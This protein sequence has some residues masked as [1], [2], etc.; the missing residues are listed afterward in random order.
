M[1]K[2]LTLLMVFVSAAISL[3]FGYKAVT[4]NRDFLGVKTGYDNVFEL[5]FDRSGAVYPEPQGE[6]LVIPRHQRMFDDFY[7]GRV[8]DYF[9]KGRISKN[10]ADIEPETLKSYTETIRSALS[11]PDHTRLILLIHGFNVPYAEARKNYEDCQR[12]I[13]GAGGDKKNVYVRLYWDG[14]CSTLFGGESGL[15]DQWLNVC[16][17]SVAVGAYGVRRFLNYLYNDTLADLPVVI[18]SH[19]RGGAVIASA[20]WDYSSARNQ[21]AQQP[22]TFQ[23]NR[24]VIG[25]LAPAMV[26]QAIKPDACK[27]TWSVIIGFNPEDEFNRKFMNPPPGFFGSTQLGCVLSECRELEKMMKGKLSRI[28]FSGEDHG[29]DHYLHNKGKIFVNEFLPLLLAPPTPE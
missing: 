12:L 10:Y 19:G 2:Y 6:Y 18:L 8:E 23:F 25:M 11:Q 26:P 15:T 21:R 24:M 29:F 14:L 22:I 20:L 7:A 4:F 16:H 3:G 9:Q 13:D 5:C 28:D 17:Q 27:S 1:N